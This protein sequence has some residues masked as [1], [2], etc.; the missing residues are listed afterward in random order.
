MRITH[1]TPNMKQGEP[2]CIKISRKQSQIDR[3]RGWI[4][5]ALIEI[6][7]CGRYANVTISELCKKAGVGRP[8][9]YRH[10]TSKEDVIRSRMNKIFECFLQTLAEI[11]FDVVTV[12]QVNITTLEHWRRNASFLRLARFSDLKRII[13][14]EADQEIERLSTLL[15]VYAEMDPYMRAFRHWG[16]KGVMLEWIKEDMKKEPQDIHAALMKL[17]TLGPNKTVAAF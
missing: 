13:F 14:S 6:S 8:T 2:D 12:E 7:E 5:D 9:F 16:M 10:F 4:E 17:N 15:K 3:T 1:P 11:G